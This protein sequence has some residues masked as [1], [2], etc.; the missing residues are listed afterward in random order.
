MRFIGL[1]LS[2]VEKRPSGFCVLNKNLEA[3]TFLVYK[4]EEILYWIGVFKPK[5]VSIDAPLAL[6]KNR[7]CLKDSCSCK[8]KGHL[9][10]CDKKL[11]EM[12]IKFF[13]LTL[14]PMRSLTLRGLKLKSL[15]EEKGFKAIETYPGAAQDLLGIP[16]KKLGIEPLRS[17][18]IK[19]GIK[20]DIIKKEISDHELDAITC[21]LTGKMYFEGEYLALGDPKEILMILP[22]PKRKNIKQRFNI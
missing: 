19:L 13:P 21:A 15:I 18:L 6:P 7:C 8:S 12:G 16:R 9:R 11:L 10:E 14:G 17:A 5:I 3:K 22:K 4:D 20:G 2:G 1:D